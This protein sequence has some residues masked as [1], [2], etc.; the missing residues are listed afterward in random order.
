MSSWLLP[1]KVESFRSGETSTQL[2]Q[3]TRFG[4]F[5]CG[6]A[7]STWSTSA[8]ISRI[9]M[10]SLIH[11][12]SDI[13]AYESGW[14]TKSWSYFTIQL[15]SSAVCPGL[16]IAPTQYVIWWI[17][18]AGGLKSM[19]SLI[20]GSICDENRIIIFNWYIIYNLIHLVWQGNR[21]RTCGTLYNLSFAL[22][23]DK[24]RMLFSI[25]QILYYNWNLFWYLIA[26]DMAL[27]ISSTMHPGCPDPPVPLIGHLPRIAMLCS[28]G[29]AC[30]P[31]RDLRVSQLTSCLASLL[32]SAEDARS[33]CIPDLQRSC[34]LQRSRRSQI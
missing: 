9:P 13:R 18:A 6:S 11:A 21:D 19:T 31:P 26:H 8:V 10:L 20:D 17:C 33:R 32:H 28:S 34:L 15:C 24:T 22:I 30:L 16:L 25:F 23:R 27:C 7:L 12:S 2:C 4:A 1:F 29:G 3:V 14:R 5:C